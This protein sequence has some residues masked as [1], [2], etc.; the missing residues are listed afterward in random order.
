MVVYQLTTYDWGSRQEQQA[1]YDKLFT[2]VTETGAK[3]VFVIYTE[4]L[5]H[6][7]PNGFCFHNEIGTTIEQCHDH[8]LDDGDAATGDLRVGEG[9]ASLRLSVE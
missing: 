4:Q 8:W 7:F 3:L 6:R 2:T 1:A 5:R 9:D